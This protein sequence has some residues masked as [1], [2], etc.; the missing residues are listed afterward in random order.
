MLDKTKVKVTKPVK[1]RKHKIINLNDSQSLGLVDYSATLVL[2]NI[3]TSKKAAAV[4]QRVLEEPNL[5]NNGSNADLGS[6]GQHLTFESTNS[7]DASGRNLNNLNDSSSMIDSSTVELPA[8]RA[9][10]I[11]ANTNRKPPKQCIEMKNGFEF[12]NNVEDRHYEKL[13]DIRHT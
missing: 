1:K 12:A 8:L 11:R 6:V 5:K 7:Q 13:M 3:Q 9:H 10:S 4:T 2:P